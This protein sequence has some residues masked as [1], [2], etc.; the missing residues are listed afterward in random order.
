MKVT[1]RKLAKYEK[2]YL[3]MKAQ[4]ALD[5]DPMTVCWPRR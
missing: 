3:E 4:E 5:E 2:E 1:S